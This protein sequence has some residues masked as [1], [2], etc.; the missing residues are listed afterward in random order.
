[1]KTIQK[2]KSEY[3]NYMETTQPHA[4]FRAKTPYAVIT[5]YQSGKVLFQG[6]R[7][8]E[9]A[10]KWGKAALDHSNNKNEDL[11]ILINKMKKQLIKYSLLKLFSTKVILERM[12]LVVVITMAI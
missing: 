2:M 3:K 12:C 10:R 7:A 4:V 6:T 5:A 9:E 1:M 8:A 11:R